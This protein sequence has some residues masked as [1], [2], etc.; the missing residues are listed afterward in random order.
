MFFEI[1][2][3]NNFGQFVY[4]NNLRQIKNDIFS[5]IADATNEF[6]YVNGGSIRYVRPY[7]IAPCCSIL[8]EMIWNRIITQ[9]IIGY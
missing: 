9:T 2:T 5:R 6:C 8:I 3:R 7:F 4:L 1:F